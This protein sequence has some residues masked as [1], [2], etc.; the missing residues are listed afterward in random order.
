MKTFTIQQ[1]IWVWPTNS[2]PWFFVYVDGDVLSN[3]LKIAKKHHIG[4][5]K[6][7]AVI[8]RTSWKT[9]MFPH[10]KENCYIMPIKKEIR[11]KEDIW[12]GDVVKIDLKLV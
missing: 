4:M 6:V 2:A 9:S 10:K 7:E 3:I 11:E 1:K 5:I 8:G 12:D